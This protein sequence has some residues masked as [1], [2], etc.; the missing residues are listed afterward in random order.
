MSAESNNAGNTRRGG[1]QKVPSIKRFT[2]ARHRTF[3]SEFGRSYQKCCPISWSGVLV[4]GPWLITSS[5]LRPS[6]E[7]CSCSRSG[8]Q[9]GMEGIYA[10]V[11]VHP[12]LLPVRHYPLPSSGSCA[13][14]Q[15]V[16]ALLY[17]VPE[18]SAPLPPGHANLSN[19]RPITA[20][21]A[22]TF[23]PGE[24]AQTLGTTHSA[25]FSNSQHTYSV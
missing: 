16:Q 15:R 14:V 8:G 7:D 2:S 25:R 18:P 11:P 5:W 1:N 13:I 20:K 21:G 3:C 24:G 4:S 17:S 12:S 19:S 10:S 6:C 22:R 9:D 23:G